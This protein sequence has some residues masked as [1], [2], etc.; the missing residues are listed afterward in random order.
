[1]KT[2]RSIEEYRDIIDLPRPED[3]MHPRMSMEKRAAQFMPFAA[4]TGY[5]RAVRDMD[6]QH[7]KAVEEEL[8]HEAVFDDNYEYDD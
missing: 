3:A 1:M 2:V 4:L 7:L 6:E 8:L 5:D